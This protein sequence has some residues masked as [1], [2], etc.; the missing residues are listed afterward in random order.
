MG[1]RTKYIHYGHSNF[2]RDLFVTPRNRR[3]FVKPSGGLWASPV[4]AKFGWKEWCEEENFRS[5]D[6]ENA[7]MFMLCPGAK[8]AHIFSRRDM[9]V[10]PQIESDHSMW[11]SLDFEKMMEQGYDA[12]ELHLSDEDRTSVGY[13]DGLY[14][15]LYGWDCDSILVL[16]PDVIVVGE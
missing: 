6:P 16:N 1:E 4:G 11:V 12:V 13:L 7:F 8:V 15:C 5:C 3:H 14:W 10:L 2:D 9:V